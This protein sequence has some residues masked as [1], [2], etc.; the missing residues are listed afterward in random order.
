[1]TELVVGEGESGAD[2]FVMI[3]WTEDQPVPLRLLDPGRYRPQGKA[4]V[5]ARAVQARGCLQATQPSTPEGLS[6]LAGPPRL[7]ETLLAIRIDRHGQFESHPLLIRDAR[8]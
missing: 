7:T 4:V 8:R 5:R 1:V 2:W 3:P 6:C